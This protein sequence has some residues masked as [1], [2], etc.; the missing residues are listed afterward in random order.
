VSVLDTDRDVRAGSAL[1]RI[2][3]PGCFLTTEDRV[4]TAHQICLKLGLL[5]I[6][7]RSFTSADAAYGWARLRALQIVAHSERAMARAR[8]ARA[9]EAVVQLIQVSQERSP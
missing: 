1:T 7:R 8:L 3:R 6:E 5:G 2:G 4:S 9:E